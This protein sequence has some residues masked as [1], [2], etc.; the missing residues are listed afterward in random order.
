LVDLSAMFSV[1]D[2]QIKKI[3]PKIPSLGH[4]PSE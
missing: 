4:C 1:W 3:I 2:A